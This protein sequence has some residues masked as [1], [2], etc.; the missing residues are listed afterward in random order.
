MDGANAEGCSEPMDIP[1]VTFD[2]GKGE[3]RKFNHEDLM[4]NIQYLSEEQI[5]EIIGIAKKA[6][7]NGHNKNSPYQS[8]EKQENTSTLSQ[9][10]NSNKDKPSYKNYSTTMK[11]IT[12]KQYINLF[13]I[14]TPNEI[15]SRIK[16]ADVWES[17]RPNNRDTILKTTKG[18]LLKSDTPKIILTN[19]LKNLQTHKKI[20]SFQETTPYKVNHRPSADQAQ[21]FS[22]VIAGVE[23]D[24]VDTQISEKLTNQD[25]DFFYCKRIISKATNKP[26]S[27]IRIITKKVN[28]FEKLLN[29][30]F[31]FKSRHY[32]IY[33]S[34]PPPPAPLPCSKCLEF[35]HKSEDCN[36]PTKCLK[37]GEKHSTTKCKSE[38]TP[39]CKS[40]G[41]ED[42][43]A[44]SFKCPNRPIKPIEGLPNIPVKLLNRKSGEITDKQK[45]SSRIHSP[46]TIHDVIVNTYVHKLNKPENINR[47]EL[48][49]KL[50]KK[51]INEYNVETSVTF[52]GNNRIYIL[53]FDIDNNDYNSPTEPIHGINNAQIQLST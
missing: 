11:G 22:C 18:Y 24:I 41:S 38:L 36:S 34:K 6:K 44:W 52:V 45:K 12:N 20:I 50:R 15:S 28:S 53:M 33:P 9:N 49:E 39:K 43:Q 23:Q 7:D 3:K 19:T 29:E 30:G 10:K 16:M 26:T 21:S 13:Y 2:P 4:V 1:P 27:F 25:I 48:L 17:T 47:N 31:F 35:T 8:S 40:C 42:H 5:Q 37:C 51:F 46:V 14:T 32:A